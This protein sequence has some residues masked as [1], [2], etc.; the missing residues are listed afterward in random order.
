MASARER[1][2][3]EIEFITSAE[4]I[5]QAALGKLVDHED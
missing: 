3:A 5:R 1:I 4:T 2:S